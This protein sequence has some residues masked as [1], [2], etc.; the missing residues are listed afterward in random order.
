MAKPSHPTLRMPNMHVR[1]SE[2]MAALDPLGLHVVM[3][4]RLITAG[5]LALCTTAP[6]LAAPTQYAASRST[7]D[8]WRVMPWPRTA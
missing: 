2:P 4:R 6:V 3:T 8:V 5:V 7:R 1:P